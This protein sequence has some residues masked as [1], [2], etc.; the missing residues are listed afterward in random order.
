MEEKVLDKQAEQV[1]DT[2]IEKA[3]DVATADLGISDDIP[4]SLR[5]K[6]LADFKQYAMRDDEIQTELAKIQDEYKA[7]MAEN[8]KEYQELMGELNLKAVIEKLKGMTKVANE[9]GNTKV[10][11]RYD[12]MVMELQSSITLEIM[13]ENI[14]KIKNPSKVFAQVQ[15]GF[16]VE[17]KKFRTKLGSS[18]TYY[19][20]DPAKVYEVLSKHIEPETARVFIYSLARFVNTKGQQRVSEYS[21]FINQIIKNIYALDGE[22]ESKDELIQSINNYVE[23]LK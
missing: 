18:K 3:L 22:F 5:N 8:E 10:V 20:T 13:M 11:A 23:A 21:I 14:R 7:M 15:S 4:E 2:Y 1:T 12:A 6:M 9:I 19:F 16:D 17:L